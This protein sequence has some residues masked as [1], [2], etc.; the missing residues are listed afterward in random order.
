M[1]IDNSSPSLKLAD[2]CDVAYALK[3]VGGKWK[4]SIVWELADG[5]R[6]R[7]SSLRRNLIN[8]SEG[9]LISQLKELERD[10]LI[11]RTV[12]PE[13]PPRV[14]YEL[15]GLGQNLVAAIKGLE[16]WGTAYRRIRNSSL[17]N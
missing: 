17:I 3:I 10:C 16:A 5:K 1:S 13:L 12:Y 9:V 4:I 8:I 11:R 2:T 15:T 14:E 6:Q 7:L